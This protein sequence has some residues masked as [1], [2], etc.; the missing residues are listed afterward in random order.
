MSPSMLTVKKRNSLGI[1]EKPIQ[2]RNSKASDL[3]QKYTRDFNVLFV[4]EDTQREEV[5]P[6]QWSESADAHCSVTQHCSSGV[7]TLKGHPHDSDG[8]LVWDTGYSGS[9][10][11]KRKVTKC[12]GGL[13]VACSKPSK[14]CYGLHVLWTCTPKVC[15]VLPKRKA[16]QL[17]SVAPWDRQ[18]WK[19]LQII[20]RST[21]GYT[22]TQGFH[23]VTLCILILPLLAPPVSC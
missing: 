10:Q 19:Q 9:W 16:K 17:H 18:G 22:H 3:I 13:V 14:L 2:K 6:F 21:L 8:H 12:F 11:R 1:Y 15:A 7:R 23:R 20:I 4:N 5:L